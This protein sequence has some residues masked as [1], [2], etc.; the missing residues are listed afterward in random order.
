MAGID[1]RTGKLISGFDH[2]VQSLSVIFRTR[3]GSRVLRRLFGSEIPGLLGKNIVPSTF[4]RFATAVHVAVE[5]WEP[6]FRVRQVTFPSDRN[7]PD[8]IR[9]GHIGIAMLGEYR[10]RALQG[11]FTVEGT[12]TVVR[13]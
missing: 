2:V 5:L 1:R 9:K 8:E 13:I 3:I 10:P 6:R 7:S 12:D 4:L 11:D